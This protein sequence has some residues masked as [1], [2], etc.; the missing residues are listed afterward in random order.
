MG[1]KVDTVLHLS[2]TILRRQTGHLWVW[3]FSLEIWVESSDGRTRLHEHRLGY[4]VLQ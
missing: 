1:E 3:S 2:H 4:E